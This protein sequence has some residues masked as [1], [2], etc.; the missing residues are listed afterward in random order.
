[1]CTLSQSNGERSPARVSFNDDATAALRRGGGGG[2]GGGGRRIDY[3]RELMRGRGRCSFSTVSAAHAAF[4]DCKERI[5]EERKELCAS[6][7][8]QF[9]VMHSPQARRCARR[10][11]THG[12]RR[13][14][15][16]VGG[17][18]RMDTCW[19]PRALADTALRLCL[20]TRRWCAGAGRGRA[21][22]L[23]HEAALLPK[24]NAVVR[25]AGQAQN[26]RAARRFP[27]LGAA[28]TGITPHPSF[29]RFPLHALAVSRCLACS[30]V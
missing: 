10:T 29:P 6:T 25:R 11:P 4:Q 17:V 16:L 13:L 23:T 22:F 7:V 1:V 9:M 15:V 5:V 12:M 3:E 19:A 20:C 24:R 2:G 30:T 28:Q 14:A 18:A 8:R 21:L 26:R 27:R